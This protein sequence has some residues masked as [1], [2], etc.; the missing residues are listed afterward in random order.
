M[1][2]RARGSLPRAQ[3]SLKAASQSFHP[4]TT[5]FH[6][7]G[8][9][10]LCASFHARQ[11]QRQCAVSAQR[12]VR[13]SP[14][15]GG[16]P[17]PCDAGAEVHA[18]TQLGLGGRGLGVHARRGL[19]VFVR[20]AEVVGAIAEVEENAA[21]RLVVH[22]A[23]PREGLARVVRGVQT[24]VLGLGEGV[25]PAPTVERLRPAADKTSANTVISC[26]RSGGVALRAQGSGAA[27][28]RGSA[29]HCE[30]G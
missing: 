30:R 1:P 4:S 28:G 10:G 19:G 2:P 11:I 5:G 18:R 21:A 29:T 3:G 6:T 20:R 8:F 9:H 15:P 27:V 17:A 25:R 12:Q 22:A 7:A 14:A 24:A 13:H 23:A 16:A 26:K